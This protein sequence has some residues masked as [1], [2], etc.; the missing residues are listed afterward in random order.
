MFVPKVPGTYHENK[1]VL[2]LA[3]N[4]RFIRFT[5]YPTAALESST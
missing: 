4:V 5:Y 2:D 1:S 3:F